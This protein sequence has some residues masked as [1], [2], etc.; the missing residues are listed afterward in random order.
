MADQLTMVSKLGLRGRI[1]RLDP[2]DVTAV[3]R[4]IRIQLAL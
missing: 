1:S 2:V 4:A 3:D